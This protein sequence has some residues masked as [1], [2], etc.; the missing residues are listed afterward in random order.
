ML[1][2]CKTDDRLDVIINYQE[3]WCTI[4]RDGRRQMSLVR[5]MLA[6]GCQNAVSSRFIQA[7]KCKK[8]DVYLTPTE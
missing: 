2:I 4:D 7:G 8:R 3:L 5:V 6:G 1:H